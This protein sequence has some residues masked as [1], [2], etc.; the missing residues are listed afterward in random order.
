MKAIAVN[1]DDIIFEN[2]NKEYGAYALRRVYS[3]N[4]IKAVSIAVLLFLAAVSAP[5]LARLVNAI[6]YTKPTIESGVIIETPP[7]IKPPV[8]PKNTQLPKPNVPAFVAPVVVVDTNEVK[9]DMMGDQDKVKND[10][11][12]DTSSIIDIG[13]GEDVDKPVIEKPKGDDKPFIWVEEMPK[14]PGGD[15]E[16]VKFL[17]NNISYPKIARE[18]GIQG[19]VYL[20][21]VVNENG[22]ITD[23][24]VI[25]GIGGGCDEEALRV[26]K[27]MPDWSPGRQN[28]V[29]VKVMLSMAINFRLESK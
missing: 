19:P 8:L 29:A 4:L 12:L 13:G 11:P 17:S 15:E 10:S 22:K 20:N 28:G 3:R 25:R 26:I 24:K 2:R 27:N 6:V 21:F 9:G 7:E 14:F 18:M 16:R 1:L 5:I 23:L